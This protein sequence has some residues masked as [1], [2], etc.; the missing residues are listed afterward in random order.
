MSSF[1]F[2]TRTEYEL[3]DFAFFDSNDALVALAEIKG[4]WSNSGEPELP[5]IHKNLE[6]LKRL[7]I[8]SVMLILTSHLTD[9]A[10][11]NYVWLADRLSIPLA[12]IMTRAFPVCSDEA[13]DWQFA[14]IGFLAG[15]SGLRSYSGGQECNHSS[16]NQAIH[17]REKAVLHG[18]ARQAG[19][20]AC[21][22][23][24]IGQSAHAIDP[25]APAAFGGAP[26][27]SKGRRRTPFGGLREKRR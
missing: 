16:I 13:G 6:G 25:H 17:T 3:Y 12:N 27:P 9:E 20:D 15:G 10:K 11:E 4:W 26:I 1:R 23:K 2:R 14:V 18:Q 5:G 24:R 7:Q 21:A 19:A 22:R 8:P